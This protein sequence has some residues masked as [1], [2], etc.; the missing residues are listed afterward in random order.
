MPEEWRWVV[1]YEDVYAISSH[2]RIFSVPR[3][4]TRGGFLKQQIR[5]DG[6]LAVTLTKDGVQ[7]LRL[8]H[9]L[10]AEAFIGKRSPGQ[11]VRHLDGGQLNCSPSNLANGTRS[12]NILDEVRHGTHRNSRKTHCPN[13]HPYDEKNTRRYQGRR[14]CI[15]CSR[16]VYPQQGHREAEVV[17]VPCAYCGK[18]FDKVLFRGSRQRKYCSDDCRKAAARERRRI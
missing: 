17:I 13:N 6:Y 5:P 9:Q 18:T 2:W 10:M 1:G 7:R 14:Y 4:T 12:E 16:E 8:V 11:E 15:A 3:T